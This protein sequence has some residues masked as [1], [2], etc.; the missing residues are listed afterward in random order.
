M[1]FFPT[2]FIC[3]G[4]TDMGLPDFFII[5]APKCGT[6]TIYDWLGQHPE[7]HAPH[8]EPC[9]FSQD[10][11]PTASLPTHISSLTEYVEIFKFVMPTQRLRG[12]ATPKYLYSDMALEQIKRL[13]PNARI[14][15]CLR[16]PVDLVISLHSQKFREGEEPEQDFVKAWR[17]TVDATGQVKSQAPTFRGQTNYLFWGLFGWRL[18]KLYD[19]FSDEQIFITTI[20]EIQENPNLIYANLVKFLGIDH[21]G[22]TNFNAS[23]VGYKIKRPL[24]HKIAVNLRHFS[25]PV[26]SRITKFRGGRGLGLLKLL[27]QFNNEKGT[28]STG[29]PE[30][31]RHEIKRTLSNDTVIANRIL[32][33]LSS[34][35]DRVC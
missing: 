15:V 25:S 14:I 24:L 8:K 22:R 13:C 6:T 20:N 23:N 16:D 30:E 4:S 29:V 35:K 31:V 32:A 3:R 12:E 7:V 11:F 1:I 18:Q 27:N 28:Y 26:L 10:I 19:V 33:S 9:F 34:G 5:G 21:D 17:R 2:T